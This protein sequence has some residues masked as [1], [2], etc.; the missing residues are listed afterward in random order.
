MGR[1]KGVGMPRAKKKKLDEARERL[2]KQ[3][4]SGDAE[5]AAPQAVLEPLAALLPAALAPTAADVLKKE[6]HEARCKAPE[7]GWIAAEL[8]N[9]VEIAIKAQ[10]DCES[11]SRRS[12]D[13]A[14]VA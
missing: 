8:Q 14:V 6:L 13:V 10:S 1:Y 9:D 5:N 4:D 12:K 11:E 3:L 7:A 2:L